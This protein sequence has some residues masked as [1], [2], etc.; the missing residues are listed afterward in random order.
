[1][2]ANC[3]LWSH[4]TRGRQEEYFKIDQKFVYV[5]CKL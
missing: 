5:D 1:M 3:M 4:H 2:A